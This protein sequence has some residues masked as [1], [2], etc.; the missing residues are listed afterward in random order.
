MN[1]NIPKNIPKISTAPAMPTKVFTIIAIGSRN[2][3]AK[4]GMLL[5]ESG[6]GLICVPQLVQN[7]LSCSVE[8]QFGHLRNSGLIISSFLLKNGE[9]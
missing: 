4:I 8:E 9:T 1:I 7:L 6:L 3:L 2:I 5:V